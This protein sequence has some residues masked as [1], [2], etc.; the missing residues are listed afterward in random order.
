MSTGAFQHLALRVKRW[1][2]VRSLQNRDR[3][4]AML[5]DSVEA[6]LAEDA[7]LLADLK[8]EHRMVRSQLRAIAAGQQSAM[9]SRVAG[10]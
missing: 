10:G 6:D 7:L 8:A 1:Y 2:V 9:V 4:L 5:V 3:N